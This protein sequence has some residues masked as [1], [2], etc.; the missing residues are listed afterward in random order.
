MFS[1]AQ[2]TFFH[3]SKRPCFPTIQD[4]LN[5]RRKISPSL[6]YITVRGE[7]KMEGARGSK[8]SKRL[9]VIFMHWH[10][11]YTVFCEPKQLL[12]TI[13]FFSRIGG[14]VELYSFWVTNQRKERLLTAAGAQAVHKPR[15]RNIGS[16]TAL[17]RVR[18]C[19]LRTVVTLFSDGEERRGF[20]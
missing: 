1:W 6:S 14:W 8:T 3:Q 9:R 11:H 5:S 4:N 15:E 7:G 12:T 16:R 17:L 18:S 2:F 19:S 13:L 10:L 20:V